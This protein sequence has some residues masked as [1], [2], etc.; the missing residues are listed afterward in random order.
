MLSSS[1]KATTQNCFCWMQIDCCMFVRQKQYMHVCLPKL[2]I[3]MYTTINI[4]FRML[5]LFLFYFLSQIKNSV[6]IQ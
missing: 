2:T 3:I 4:Y 1:Y 5:N 6:I